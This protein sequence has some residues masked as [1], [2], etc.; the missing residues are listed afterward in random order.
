MSSME[1]I[2]ITGAS[3]LVGQYLTPLLQGSG[4]RVIHLSRTLPENAIVETFTWDVHKQEID[5]R[6]INEADFIIH[7]AGAGIAEKSWTDAR[8]KEIMGSRVES[9]QLLFKAISESKKRPNGFVCASA[10]GFYGSITTDKIYTETDEPGSDFVATTCKFWESAAETIVKLGIRVVKIRTG[11]V[12][13]NDGG[14]LPKMTRPVKFCLGSAFGTGNQYIPW[15]HVEDLCNI[16]LKAIKD[17][18]MQG[19]YNA[20]APE[21]ITNA[22]FMRTVAKVL[23]R[24]LVL[25]A[26]PAFVLK[27]ILGERATIVLDGSRVSCEKIKNTGYNFKFKALLPALT[28]L[29]Q[30]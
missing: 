19:A 15:I 14:A 25:P 10:I 20:V 22:G 3:G 8:K 28:N 12:L 30:K 29:F 13:S 9:T 26:I 27:F 21:F 18:S 4:Y 7:L 5:S 6:A 17:S 2:L 16:Y 24:P 23:H 11:I 1:T